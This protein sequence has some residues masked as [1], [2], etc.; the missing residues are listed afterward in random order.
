M[1]AR[2]VAAFGWGIVLVSVGVPWVVALIRG[3]DP[4]SDASAATNALTL[5]V[6]VTGVI[7]IAGAATRARVFVWV[8]GIVTLALA[9]LGVWV[10]LDASGHWFAPWWRPL[11]FAVAAALPAALLIQR[12]VPRARQDQADARQPGVG[13]TVKRAG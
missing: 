1:R 3:F 5:G 7:V 11:A 9:A 13:P 12:P 4:L 2:R 10:N 8:L 6:V